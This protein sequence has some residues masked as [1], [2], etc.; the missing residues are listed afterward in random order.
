MAESSKAQAKYIL[1]L[2]EYKFAKTKVKKYKNIQKITEK[3]QL[4][5]TQFGLIDQMDEL[6]PEML[7]PGRTEPKPGSPLSGRAGP[8]EHPWV[9][10][11][12]NLRLQEFRWSV[13]E[14]D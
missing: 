12:S 4:G 10:Q 8:D 2:V 9:G 1:Q 3:V 13:C 5:P 6:E 7:Q 11:V 14:K